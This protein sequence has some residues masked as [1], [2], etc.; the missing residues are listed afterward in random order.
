VTG[1]AR[2]PRLRDV[3]LEQVRVTWLGLRIPSLVGVGLAGLATIVALPTM[4]RG[5][6]L[7]ING[8]PTWLPGI[9]GA[10]LPI[11]VWGKDER[12][13]PGFLW[14]LP[15]DRRRH[16]L[17][18]IA[19]GWIWLMAGVVVFLSWLFVMVGVTGEHV[20]PETINLVVSGVPPV[21]VVDPATVRRVHWDPGP[22]MG[23]VAFSGATACYL[24]GSALVLGVR[25]PLR[26]VL[27]V[28]ALFALTAV[29]GGPVG[30]QF[31][32]VWLAGAPGRLTELLVGSRYGLDALLTARSET[33]STTATLTTGKSL[34][35][36]W[37]VPDLVDWGVA[38]VL[39]TGLGAIALW[40]AVSR[41]G[42][43]RRV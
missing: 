13:G 41:H 6:P 17:T 25:H 37:G 33:L 34:R 14:T 12:F 24:I 42:E 43:R 32:I 11:A 7:N 23:L 19:A 16:A 35:V 40:T 9:M 18:K 27:G 36:W 21:T 28:A 39:W 26:W 20:L 3:L 15:V 22:L 2:Q 4:T 30:T 1:K 5:G 8:W 31:G 38:T 10:L 29:I